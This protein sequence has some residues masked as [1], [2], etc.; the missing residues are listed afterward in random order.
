MRGWW[1]RRAL[2]EV[3]WAVKGWEGLRVGSSGAEGRAAG[4]WEDGTRLEGHPIDREGMGWVGGRAVRSGVCV[5]RG[6]VES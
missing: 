1:G 3:V 4:G 5:V 2:S 6:S